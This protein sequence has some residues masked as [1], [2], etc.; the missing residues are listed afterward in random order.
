MGLLQRGNGA[1][2]GEAQRLRNKQNLVYNLEEITL[3]ATMSGGKYWDTRVARLTKRL[4]LEYSL[5]W[6]LN[7]Q[8]TSYK[9][10]SST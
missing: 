4:Q 3:K 8:K 5:Q 1:E 7:P 9:T 6:P 2:T 10:S